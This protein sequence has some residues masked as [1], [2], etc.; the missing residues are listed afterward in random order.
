MLFQAEGGPCRPDKVGLAADRL[1][2]RPPVD[3][4][5]ARVVL[6]HLEPQ[7]VPPALRRCA[8]RRTDQQCGRYLA[9]KSPARPRPSRDGP[10]ANLRGRARRVAGYT[11][12]SLGDAD[13][14]GG[15]AD[16]VAKGFSR[17]AGRSRTRHSRSQAAHRHHLREPG[18]CRQPC[19]TRKPRR[20]RKTVGETDA[21]RACH[22]GARTIALSLFDLGRI[23]TTSRRLTKLLFG[24]LLAEFGG[25][26]KCHLL[27]GPLPTLR[28]CS[29]PAR[30]W[31]VGFPADIEQLLLRQRA[32]RR[33]SP[34][35]CPASRRRSHR[36]S[37]ACRCPSPFPRPRRSR[38]WR[39]GCLSRPRREAVPPSSA[40]PAAGVRRPARSPSAVRSGAIS[41]RPSRFDSQP[42]RWS[43]SLAPT[44]TAWRCS[45]A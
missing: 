41:V 23:V 17:Q 1:E 12:A 8:L 18:G 3:G 15:T 36:R 14:G 2:T 45:A 32:G 25:T 27:S 38:R 7:R 4:D 10:S 16:Q 29:A 19:V 39:C 34:S 28:P 44:S 35:P 6:A 42:S 24:S 31:R 22:A 5:G 40:P 13:G 43:L 26:S 37:P 30:S 9:P 20:S 21:A 11:A 33:R